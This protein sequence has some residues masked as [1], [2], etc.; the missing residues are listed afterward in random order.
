MSWTLFWQL[1]LLIGG[2]IIL[3]GL[4]VESWIQSWHKK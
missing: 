3:V 1:A 4:I 2:T